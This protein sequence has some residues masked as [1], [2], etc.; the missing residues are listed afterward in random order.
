MSHTYYNDISELD[1]KKIKN[2]TKPFNILL[3]Q[4]LSKMNQIQMPSSR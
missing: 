2:F 4:L 3:I 1:K